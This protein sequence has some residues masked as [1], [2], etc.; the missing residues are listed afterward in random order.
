MPEYLPV[1]TLEDLDALDM[2]EVTEG[3][4]FGYAGN[5]EPNHHAVSRSFW[6]GWRN[7]SM[8]AGHLPHDAACRELAAAFN[9]RAVQIAAQMP[10]WAHETHNYPPQ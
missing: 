1:T 5:P 6:H 10:A 4:R 9:A 8:D 3:Y 7:G 2:D